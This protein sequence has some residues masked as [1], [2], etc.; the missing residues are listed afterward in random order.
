ML[1]AFEDEVDSLVHIIILLAPSEI[2]V[3]IPI[4]FL[5]MI[6]L[7]HESASDLHIQYKI[8]SF[9]NPGSADRARQEVK[10][11]H[12]VIERKA[13]LI[14]IRAQ[15]YGLLNTTHDGLGT[16]LLTRPDKP[17]FTDHV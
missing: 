16:P 5:V 8:H 10:H 2:L 7:K 12:G 6:N 13:W 14:C 3:G 9:R 11:Y 4:D 15:V 17:L 1:D